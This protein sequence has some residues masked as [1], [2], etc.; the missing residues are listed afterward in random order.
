MG[1]AGDAG[2]LGFLSS[3]RVLLYFK[4]L[5]IKTDFFFF[6]ANVFPVPRFMTGY[7]IYLS[8][9][10][11]TITVAL[12]LRDTGAPAGAK[13]LVETRP[14][15]SHTPKSLFLVRINSYQNK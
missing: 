1:G 3:L 11:S 5:N 2:C 14:R 4:V 10:W 8:Q 7:V 12:S 13:R 15:K 9:P 6:F